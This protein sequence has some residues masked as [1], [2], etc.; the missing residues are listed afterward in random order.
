MFVHLSSFS[1]L[2]NATRLY[3][4]YVYVE[5]VKH[6][7]T[8]SLQKNKP[9]FIRC[10]IYVRRPTSMRSPMSYKNN[11]LALISVGSMLQY[12]QP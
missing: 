6:K 1:S 8:A 9:N 10:T 2:A 12:A 4:M 7:C 11:L 5:V 3:C